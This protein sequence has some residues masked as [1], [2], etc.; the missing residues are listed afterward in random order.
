MRAH[1]LLIAILLALASTATL[2]LPTSKLERR[3][4]NTGVVRLPRY[5]AFSYEIPG[6]G[7]FKFEVG[8]KPWPY[9]RV[10]TFKSKGADNS[11]SFATALIKVI[12]YNDAVPIISSTSFVDFKDRDNSW[13]PFTISNSTLTDGA[14]SLTA[15]STLTIPGNP[16]TANFSVTT[17]SKATNITATLP[18][19]TTRRM[20][21]KVTE[22]KFSF[23]FS[24]FTYTLNNSNLAIVSG[25][26]SQQQRRP[27]RDD[28]PNKGNYTAPTTVGFDTAGY[29][30]WVSDVLVPSGAWYNI[31]ADAAL[32]NATGVNVALPGRSMQS[33]NGN[34]NGDDAE[35][36]GFSYPGA[37][38]A[39][40]LVHRI[41][42]QG[43]RPTSFLWDPTL[44][45]ND[46]DPTVS[47]VL[48]DVAAAAANDGVGGTVNVTDSTGSTAVPTTKPSA[49]QR[50]GASVACFATVFL[51]VSFL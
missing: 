36:N 42:L 17:V 35:K 20:P 39:E 2:A 25:L 12:E 10:S 47:S 18:N 43:T 45:L 51:A 28:G 21:M 24:G 7:L 34:G 31:S 4:L 38:S 3:R 29:L 15:L 14:V 22:L 19:N 8:V 13:S 32:Y 1:L 16:F 41:A 5:I 9:L 40:F 49:A 33:G 11:T 6:K 44:G 50:V 30:S 46:T 27:R 48:G 37:E 23:G 26:F